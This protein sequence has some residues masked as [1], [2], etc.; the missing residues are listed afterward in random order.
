[1]TAKEIIVRLNEI[2]SDFRFIYVISS[3]IRRDFCGPMEDLEYRS[4]HDHFN[5]NEASFL[6][7]LWVKN[8]RGLSE[9]H[10]DLSARFKE[11]YSMMEQLH[12]TFISEGPKIFDNVVEP[13]KFLTNGYL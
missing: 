7:G 3:F 11:A 2:T 12:F 8:S 13:A 10:Y 5:Y 1:M 6:I 4:S 9:E